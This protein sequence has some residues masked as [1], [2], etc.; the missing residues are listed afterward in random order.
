MPTTG[1]TRNTFIE[2]KA[3]EAA[4]LVGRKHR[5]T[6][7]GDQRQSLEHRIGAER[8]DDR[9]QPQA[10]G[11]HAVDEAQNSAEADA[12]QRGK[13][14]IDARHHHQRGNDGGKIEHPPD[15]EIDFPDRQQKNHAERHHALE[16]GVAE[17][18]QKID[19]IEKA[20]PCDADDDDH[21]QQSDDDP[22]FLGQP[23]RAPA[24][25]ARLRKFRHLGTTARPSGY[26]CQG[27]DSEATLQL[28]IGACNPS[29]IHKN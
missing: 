22:D 3:E 10:D 29:S 15:R 12:S 14:G 13:P 11:K 5:A 7:V 24:G 18:R 19:R 9:R 4:R 1:T 17:D 6:L 27:S 25:A 20:R 2:A 16:R 26:F 28:G 8:H 23:K 21:D